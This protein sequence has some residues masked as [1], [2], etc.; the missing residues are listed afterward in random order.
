MATT[1]PA[2]FNTVEPA[3]S[4]NEASLKNRSGSLAQIYRETKIN[5]KN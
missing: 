4:K 1:S 3:E 2:A 5:S